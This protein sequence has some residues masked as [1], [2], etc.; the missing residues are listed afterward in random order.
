[1]SIDRIGK[2]GSVG[3]LTGPSAAKPAA[4]RAFEVTASKPGTTA[5][6]SLADRVRRGEIDMA[7]YVELRVEQAT[8]HLT[9]KLPEATLLQVR[10]LLKSQ[11]ANDPALQELVKAATGQAAPAEPDE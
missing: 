9:N 4:G 1:M 7:T 2:S 3:G 11:L 6:A 5:E 10:E 8:Q